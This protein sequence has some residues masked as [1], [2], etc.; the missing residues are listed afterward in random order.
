MFICEQYI[1]G[2]PCSVLSVPRQEQVWL[3]H[4]E[5]LVSLAH[6]SGLLAD[7]LKAQ[8]SSETADLLTRLGVG[9]GATSL[10]M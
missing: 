7:I 5:G 6:L 8:D 9:F 10:K 2:G 3:L 4:V 1:L